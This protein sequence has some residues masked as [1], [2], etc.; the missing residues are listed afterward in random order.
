LNLEI[1]NLKYIAPDTRSKNPFHSLSFTATNFSPYHLAVLPLDIILYNGNLVSGV[2]IYNLNNF[3]SGEEREINF[4]WPAAG[5][6]VS[7]VEILADV[8]ILDSQ[9]YLPYQGEIQP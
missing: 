1:S 6:R 3:L 7:K 2:N 5:E 8:N 4:S 9:V